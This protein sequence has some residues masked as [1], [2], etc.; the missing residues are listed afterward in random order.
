MKEG[1]RATGKETLKQKN[2]T[3]RTETKS[4]DIREIFR[5][6]IP[7]KK[8][9]LKEKQEKKPDTIIIN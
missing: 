6:K 2:R 5:G 7:S 9:R 8:P 3:V 1:H 4:V